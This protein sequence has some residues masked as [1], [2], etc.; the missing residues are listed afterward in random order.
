MSTMTID[1]APPDRTRGP[2]C[3]ECNGPTRLTGIEPHPT[4]EHM[5]LRTFECLICQAVQ[6]TV[7]AVAN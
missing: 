5:D 3:V 2:A 7:V 1:L 4:R 6:T